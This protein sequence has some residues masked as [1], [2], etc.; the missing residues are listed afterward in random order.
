L[1]MKTAR[2]LVLSA[3]LAP[4][5]AAD[6]AGERFTVEFQVADGSWQ[7]EPLAGYP[8]DYQI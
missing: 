4:A 5:V 1:P 8:C 7:R 3:W 6:A 2:S